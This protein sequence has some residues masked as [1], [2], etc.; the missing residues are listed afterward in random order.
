MV[1]RIISDYIII[2]SG[3]AGLYAAHLASKFGTVSLLTKHSLQTSSTYWAQGGIASAIDEEDSPE[4]HFEDTI[5]AGRG[6][7]NENAVRIL[8]SE[9]P[10]RINE[11]ISD[12]LSFD[13]IGNSYELGL[14]GGHTR[15]RVL[16]LGGNE[17]GRFIVEFLSQR[18]KE[19]KN[20][21]VF[22]NFLVHNLNIN[23]KIC[24]G[25]FA[26]S[27]NKKTDYTFSSSVTLI[28]TGGAAGIYKRSTNP[29]SSIGDGISLAYKAGIDVINMEFIQFHPT[30]FYYET[31][32]T[33]LISEAVRG[34]GAYL[35]DKNGKRFM[36]DFHQSAELAPRDVVSKG[37]FQVMKEQNVEYVFLSLS[38]LDNEKIKTRFKNIYEASLKYKIDLT[39]D[40]IPVSPAAHYTIGG[41]G[42]GLNGETKI[43]GLYAIGEVAYTG[44]H[45]ANRLAS[46]SLLE[47]LVFSFRAI[48]DSLKRINNNLSF[49]N[50]TQ[51]YFVD[52]DVN[53]L[54][55]KLKHDV[56]NIM[57]RSVGIVR[58]KKSLEDAL[59]LI[60]Q[61][62]SGWNYK[63]NEY[64]SDRLKSLKMVAS[65]VIKGAICREESRGCHIRIDFPKEDKILYN[66]NQSINAGITRIK[67]Y[68]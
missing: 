42:T 55:L 63:K 23:D 18:I 2:G 52:N 25:C 37:I 48:E 10:K 54:Y 29:H 4:L 26:Y 47:C 13:K 51:E 5:R 41:I 30:A 58:A 68:A 14:E 31:G 66:I 62:D 61:I 28:A 57:N 53:S 21:T 36:K 45:G 50:G 19:S 3:L 35:L 8:V 6:L 11:F 44:V 56:H 34:E 40:L 38:H 24:Y 9:G 33:F 60:N 59:E 43:A 32:K 65:L 22:E 39:K 15:R 20:I 67:L 16:H 1:N 49:A 7:C 17:T 64:Y 12:G 27:W 46:N